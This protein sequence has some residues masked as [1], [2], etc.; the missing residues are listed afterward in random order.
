MK[1]GEVQQMLTATNRWWRNPRDWQRDDPDLREADGA[2]FRYSAGVLDD[3]APGGLYVLRGPRRVGKSV[4]LKRAIE[5]LVAS[6]I[7]PR[8]IVH[9]AVDGWRAADLGR[10]VS[11]AGVLM[12]RD[13]RRYWFID[14]ITG[15]TD[16]WPEQ[17]KW[18]RDN[19]ARLRDDTVVLTGSSASDLTASIKAL[20][21]RRGSAGDPDRVLLPMGFRTFSRLAAEEPVGIDIGPLRVADLTP[22]LL[23]DAAHALAPWLHALVDTWE[24]YLLAGGFP[25]AVASYIDTREVAPPLV[26]GLVDVVHGDA[27]RRADWSRAQTAA[28]MHRIGRGLCAPVNISA[29]ADDIGVSS[30]SVQRRLDELREAFVVWPCYQE[31]ALRPKLNA[32]AKVYF[33]DPVY[34]RLEVDVPLDSSVLSEQQLGTALWRSLE[35]A[36]AG[37]YL[38]Y[39]RILYHRTRTRREIDFVGP[40]LGGWAVESKYVD[41]R[42]RRDA[43][44]L[45]ASRWRGIVAT[46]SELNFDD[47]EVAAVPAAMLAWLL[48]T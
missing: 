48:D 5:S 37:S 38:G 47:P 17:V 15:I 29:V 22:R 19:D 6:G 4:E 32:Q 7:A 16:G 20:A 14:E 27:F 24:G 26:R 42:W 23:A 11:A 41:G 30:S 28:F 8:S 3:L 35:R 2:P 25:A 21:G 31:D 40:D 46:R 44:T 45:L 10:L 33:T 9:A 36:R 43:Q 13:G 12:P 34:A 18:L 1:Q 39:D